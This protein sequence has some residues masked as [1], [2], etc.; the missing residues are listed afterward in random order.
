MRTQQQE[1][2]VGQFHVMNIDAKILN[3]MLAI[4]FNSTLK[5]LHV[6]IKLASSQ[7]FKDGF[8]YANQ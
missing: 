5:R 8:T 2:T 7:D 1:N 4:K 3:K 6:M